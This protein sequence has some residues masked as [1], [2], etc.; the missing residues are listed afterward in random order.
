MKNKLTQTFYL[1][2]FFSLLSCNDQVDELTSPEQDKQTTT[3]FS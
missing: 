3:T 1:T 2:L